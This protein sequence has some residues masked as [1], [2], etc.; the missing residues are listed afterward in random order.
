MATV[1]V[2][3]HRLAEKEYDDASNWYAQRSAETALHFKNAVDESVRRIAQSPESFPRISGGYRRIRVQR[4]RYIL[5]FRPRQPDEMV[6]VA[7]AHTSR[8]PGYWR[9]RQI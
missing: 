3:F 7:V 5:V 6:V 2:E 9:R 4:F 1:K 8:R